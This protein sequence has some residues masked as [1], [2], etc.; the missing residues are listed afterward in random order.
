LKIEIENLTFKTIIGILDFERVKKQRVIVNLKAKY[1]YKNQEFINYVE[2]CDL[3]K[4]NIKTS[5]F[6]LLEDALISTAD[7]ILKKY[8]AIKKIKIKITKPDILKDADVSL[9]KKF[10]QK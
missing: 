5:K 9:S 1:S 8:K 2:L 7:K 3:I 4:D 6:E 10:K